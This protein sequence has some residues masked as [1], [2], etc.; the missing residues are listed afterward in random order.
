MSPSRVLYSDPS[1]SPARLKIKDRNSGEV[2]TL[3]TAPDRHHDHGWLTP[4]GAVFSALGSDITTER[5]YE[6]SGGNDLTDLGPL[7]SALSPQVRG[8]YAIWSNGTTL[9]RRNVNTHQT[10]V[11]ATDAGNWRNDLLPNGEVIYWSSGREYQIKRYHDGA[12]E[13][14]T[15][16]TTLWNFYPVADGMNVVYAKGD[17]CCRDQEFAVW[18][19]DGSREIQLTPPSGDQP[20]QGESYDVAGGWTAFLHPDSDG[21]VQVRVRDPQGGISRLS[22]IGGSE[23]A[24]TPRIVAVNADGQ[25][26]YTVSDA[27]YLGAPGQ[28]AVRLASDVGTWSSRFENQPD[29]LATYFDGRWHLAIGD[30][31]YALGDQPR[32]TLTVTVEGHGTVT[33]SPGTETCRTT[34]SFD[35]LQ[36][37]G[38]T[39]TET[40]DLPG[41]RF[42]G[43]SGDCSGS[44]ATCHLRLDSASSVHA[45]FVPGDTTAPLT[46]PPASHVPVGARLSA[47][48]PPGVP[49]ETSWTAIDPDDPVSTNE[50]QVSVNGGGFAP[51][52]LPT[53]AAT[54]TTSRVV[55]TARYQFRAR[56]TDSHGNVGDWATGVPLTVDAFQETAGTYEGAWRSE[57]RA[58]AWGGTVISTRQPSASVM[59]TVTGR[60]VAVVGT[61]GRRHGS[62][63]VYVDGELRQTRS[64]SSRK[65]LARRV[66]ADV[67]FAPGTHTIRVVRA[68]DDRGPITLDGF[69]VLR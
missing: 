31:L 23:P 15:H 41:W 26:A 19:H 33:V 59:L 4:L 43:W 34:C 47:R 9:Y 63:Q 56:A 17:P 11:V 21:R 10:T 16:D 60:E 28:P 45:R 50:L 68:P 58:S 67:K 35:F 62:L 49:L 30:S 64:T 6:W 2:T 40:A 37:T 51:V 52:G 25:V 7:N 24:G 22:D 65:T 29:N 12:T 27:L 5:L 14:L 18:L 8:T 42:G 48:I 57:H 53:V 44:E 55:P 32:T 13:Q 66:L 54:R 1:T 69:I 39:L 20:D 3:P 46:S 38:V 36:G 61:T